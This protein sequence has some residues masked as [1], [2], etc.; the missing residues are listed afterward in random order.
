MTSKHVEMDW[1]ASRFEMML[2]AVVTLDVVIGV[3]RPAQSVK[4]DPLLDSIDSQA[5]YAQ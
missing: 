2:I 1:E 4:V 3:G 5:Y